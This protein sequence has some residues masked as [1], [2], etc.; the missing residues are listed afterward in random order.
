MKLDDIDAKILNALQQ[1]ARIRTVDLAERVGLSATP[2][3][4]RIKILEDEG[5]IRQYTTLVDPEKVGYSLNVFIFVQLERKTDAH[6]EAFEAEIR[7][8]KEV[9]ECHLVTGAH[10]YLLRLVAHD[11]GG[12]EHFI[13]G[14]LTKIEGVKDVQSFFSI[15]RPTYKTALPVVASPKSE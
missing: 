2:C 7:K 1:D 3:Q 10:D 13:T 11:I 5:Y 15:R 9:M 4:R 14:T 8:C 6:F 12:Y